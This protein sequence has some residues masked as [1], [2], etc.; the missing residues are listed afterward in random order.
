MAVTKAKRHSQPACGRQAEN[1]ES[2]WL[3][4]HVASTKLNTA[5]TYYVITFRPH[6]ASGRAQPSHSP[7]LLDRSGEAYQ[8]V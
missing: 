8:V 6:G 3:L 1:D 2:S 7:F 5:F 4:R